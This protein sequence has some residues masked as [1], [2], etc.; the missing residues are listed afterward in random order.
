MPTGKCLLGRYLIVRKVNKMICGFLNRKSRNSLFAYLLG[1]CY[2]MFMLSICQ[3]FA[4]GTEFC[5]NYAELGGKDICKTSAAATSGLTDPFHKSVN[6][7]IPSS[8]VIVEFVNEV[9]IDIVKAVITLF[10]V[11]DPI[12]IIPLFAS[13]TERMRP[14]ERRSISQ[15]AT[16][17][18]G[19]LLF[20]FAIAGTQIFSIFGIDVFSFMIAGGILLFIVSIELL[21]HGSWRFGQ[22]V[23]RD[24]SGVVPLAFPL[25]AGPGSITSV[26][27]LYQTSGV[28]VT[29]LSIIIVISL[30]YII[31]LLA[32]PIYRVLGRRG[33]MVVT[34]VFAIL[35]AAFAIQ[36]IVE[37]IRQI[38]STIF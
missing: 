38:Y 25:L 27:I 4:Y 30:T 23:R 29:V 12:G 8:H 2:L 19:V 21:T 1:I 28:I 34:R 35:V 31:L 32:S 3:D 7:T 9:G 33:S 5:M 14:E 20:V 36:Y 6:N 17:T 11:I 24:D 37:G 10:V 15:T 22:D 18:A 16:I 26:I 13:F